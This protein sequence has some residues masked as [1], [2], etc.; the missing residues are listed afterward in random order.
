[1]KR[2]FIKYSSIFFLAAV[3][4]AGGTSIY[5]G[6]E[7]T[8]EEI[9]ANKDSYDG[10]EVSISGTVSGPRFKASKSGKPYMTFPLLGDSGGRIN[11]FVWG[12]MKLKRGQKVRVTGIYRKSVEMGKYSFR[13]MIEAGEFKTD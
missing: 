4:L 7:P 13:D 11:I 2:D 8:V 10:K 12:N 5:A 1:M 3:I 9:M 6:V